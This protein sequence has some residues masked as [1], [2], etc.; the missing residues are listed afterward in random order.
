MSQ[1]GLEVCICTS[2]S[3]TGSRGPR[4]HSVFRASVRLLGRK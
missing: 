2:S 3:H 4:G 1:S